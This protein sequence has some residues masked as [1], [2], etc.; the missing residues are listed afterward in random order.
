MLQLEFFF[1]LI[2]IDKIIFCMA[3]RYNFL[4]NVKLFFN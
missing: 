4:V 1:S 3:L 2:E